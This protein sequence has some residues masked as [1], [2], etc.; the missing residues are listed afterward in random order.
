VFGDI[1][2]KDEFDVVK[3][4]LQL[5]ID[6]GVVYKIYND[7]LGYPTF[8]IGHLVTRDDPEHGQPVDTVVSPERV[9]AAFDGDVEW[10]LADC[11]RVFS[12]WQYYPSEAQQVFANM[13]FNMGATRLAKFKKMIEAA[14][15]GEWETA[16][17]EG[18]DSVWYN[19]VTKRAERLMVRL[20]AIQ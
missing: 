1:F 3:L 17:K 10:T 4:R 18:R 8:G 14:N 7:H 5:V 19:Q 15:S 11:R 2:C 20:E 9:A 6:E 12:S 13:M 16:A